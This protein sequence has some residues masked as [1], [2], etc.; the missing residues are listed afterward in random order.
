MK[1]KHYKIIEI[2]E[3]K[4]HIVV[5]FIYDDDGKELV[6]HKKLNY[7]NDMAYNDTEEVIVNVEHK[8]A[9]GKT[10]TK[11]E[12]VLQPVIRYKKPFNVSDPIELDS[13]LKAYAQAYING[14]ETERAMIP[15]VSDA[16]KNLIG[17]NQV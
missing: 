10:Y 8:D 2:I 14:V 7:G 15:I 6:R 5:D 16:V 13:Q 1:L 4:A 12:R 9:D 11:P 3:D 17:S